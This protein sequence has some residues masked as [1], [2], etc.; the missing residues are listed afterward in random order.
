MLVNFPLPNTFLY[1]PN[2]TD[3]VA[4]PN[5]M[6]PQA[7]KCKEKYLDPA[8]NTWFSRAKFYPYNIY[9]GEWYRVKNLTRAY[10]YIRKILD[11][12]LIVTLAL[13][14]SGKDRKWVREKIPKQDKIVNY[15]FSVRIEDLQ[16]KAECYNTIEEVMERAN[17]HQ[18]IVTQKSLGRFGNIDYE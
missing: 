5:Y 15:F 9:A 2:N 6:W 12:E 14:I 1:F 11:T 18:E 16:H 13:D 17:I 10:S 8:T 3:W 4:R 7:I